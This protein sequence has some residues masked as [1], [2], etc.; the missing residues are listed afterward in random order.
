MN[1][2]P[3]IADLTTKKSNYCMLFFFV[4]NIYIKSAE[5]M[6]FLSPTKMLRERVT[7]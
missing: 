1:E 2:I 3:E 6:R 5:L 7:E 4:G